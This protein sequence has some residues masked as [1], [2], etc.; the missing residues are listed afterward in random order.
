M[1]AI[2]S[3]PHGTVRHS[4]NPCCTAALYRAAQIAQLGDGIVDVIG[5]ARE[6]GAELAAAGF[7]LAPIVLHTRRS[8]MPSWFPLD[9]QGLRV[10]DVGSCITPLKVSRL[11]SAA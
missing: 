8:V 4:G 9:N 3:A 2:E 5:D 10:G 11:P 6:L 1:Q 7:T